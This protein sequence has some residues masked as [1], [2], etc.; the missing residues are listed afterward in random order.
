MQTEWPAERFSSVAQLYGPSAV[1]RF[2]HARVAVIGMGGVGSWTVE[3]LARSGVGELILYDLDDVCVSNTNRQIHTLSDTVGGFKVSVMAE[4]CRQIN[5]A[6]EVVERCQFITPDNLDEPTLRTVDFVVDAIDSVRPKVALIAALQRWGT[7]FVMTGGA[8]GQ[9]DPTQIHV[10]DLAQVIQDP[11]AASVRRQLRRHHGY[12]GGGRTMK[13][14]CVSS[15]EPL[16]YPGTAE[17]SENPR[18]SCDFGLGASVAVTA[19]FGLVAAELVLR[20]LAKAEESA[21]RK[22]LSAAVEHSEP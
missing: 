21:A 11:L 1:Q 17:R 3:A 19:T 12:P 18:L 2:R 9:K 15:T 22:T 20:H 8:G 14:A 16:T 7:P 10:A 13:V 5:P 6:I 4:R